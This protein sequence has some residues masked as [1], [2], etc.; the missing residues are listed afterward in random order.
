MSVIINIGRDADN[1]I[2]MK[3][4]YISG[5]HAQLIRDSDGKWFIHDLQSSNGTFVNGIKITYAVGVTEND[6]VLL[7]GSLLPLRDILQ[8]YKTPDHRRPLPE[9]KPVP[10]KRRSY[11]LGAA[12]TVILFIGFFAA[13]E[14]FFSPAAAKTG[15]TDS[16]R[17][18]IL[19]DGEK[20]KLPKEITYD[21]SCVTYSDNKNVD[22]VTNTIDSFYIDYVG[23]QKTEV[24]LQE[25]IDFGNKNHDALLKGSTI[26]N[27]AESRHLE[28]MLT[29]LSSHISQP[30]GFGYKIFLIESK[31]INSWTSGGRIYFTTAMLHF[32]KNDDEVAGILGHEINHNELK[33][34]NNILKV[35]KIANERFGDRTGG[36]VSAITKIL[37]S[38]FGKKDEAHCDLKGID[39]VIASGYNPC[40]V[41]DL[42]T[43]MSK[44]EE[45]YDPYTNFIRTHPYSAVRVVCIRHHLEVNYNIKC[46]NN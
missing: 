11:I 28:E 16:T 33:H 19:K 10:K 7:G 21:L 8:K 27:N 9:Y 36:T 37:S 14:Y 1:D 4:S 18:G 12:A 43:R 46:D 22:K 25:E 24:T 44:L 38:P 35:Q 23:K 30:R 6:S 17:N 3:E 31:E 34:I 32:A 2:V 42:W 20:D 39:I 15:K 26:L 40:H 29:V 13:N 45:E 41:I 5:H